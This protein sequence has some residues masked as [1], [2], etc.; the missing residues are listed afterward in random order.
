VGETNELAAQFIAATK[1]PDVFSN[2]L[3]SVGTGIIALTILIAGWLGRLIGVVGM[4][5][6]VATSQAVLFVLAI[7]APVVAVMAVVPQMRWLRGLWLKSVAVLALLPVAAGGIFKAGVSLAAYFDGGGLAAMLIRL[8]WLWGAVGFLLSLAG[9]LGKMTLSSAIDTTVRLGKA[10][11]SLRSNSDR[12]GRGSPD[13]TGDAKAPSKSA[14]QPAAQAPVPPHF[15][16]ETALEAPQYLPS[17]LIGGEVSRK[18]VS[19]ESVVPRE[20]GTDIAAARSDV[21]AQVFTPA[22]SGTLSSGEEAPGEF[23]TP[24][25]VLGENAEESPSALLAEPGSDRTAENHRRDG[26]GS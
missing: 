5:A 22:G 7:V 25:Q 24:F 9:I 12:S 20:P 26:E 15:L 18:R 3:G 10:I 11:G 17:R 16:F 21:P 2:L 14:S 19:P 4:A 6:A 8:F 13:S 1:T 23:S